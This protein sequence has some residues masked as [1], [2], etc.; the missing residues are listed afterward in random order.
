MH[1]G[2]SRFV[3]RN[4]RLVT[5]AKA[6][7]RLRMTT[8]T[9]SRQRAIRSYLNTHPVRKLQLG[10]GLNLLYGWLNTDLLPRARGCVFLDATKPFPF[11]D[12]TFDYIFSE[13][14]IQTLTYLEGSTMLQECYRVLK[15]SGRVR[16]A[17]LSLDVLVGLMTFEEGDAQ[18]RYI[19]WITDTALPEIGVYRAS[20]VVNNAFRDWGHQFVYDFATLKN[21]LEKSKFI[22]VNPYAPGESDT[23][24]LKGIEVH[25]K[26]V[27]NEEMNRFETMVIEASRPP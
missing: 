8:A 25:G 12:A 11:E 22:N 2:L 1:E 18:Q 7:I 19:H 13:H 26:A 16:I 6:A 24:E 23:D 21:S 27:D 5:I 14:Q 20:I 17:A 15:P 10:A 4:P 9:L 3:R